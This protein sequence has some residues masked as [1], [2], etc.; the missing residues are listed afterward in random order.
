MKKI[1]ALML[2]LIMV[3]ALVL[4]ACGGGKKDSDSGEPAQGSSVTP[5]PQTSGIDYMALVNKLN[6]LPDGWEE[7]LETVHFTNTVGDDV[8]VEKKAYDAYLELKAELEKEGI[9]VDLD[10]A[11]RS[12]ADQERIMND[13]IEKYG[14]DYAFKT[15]AKPGYSEHH[16]GLALDL[17]LIIDGKDIVENED[18]VQYP[19]IWAKIHSKLANH[20]FIL[21]Y[22]EGRE[23][24]TG[25]G[26]EPWHIRYID[27]VAVAKEI[28]E[29]DI[30]LEEY[31]GAVKS[32]DV[33]IE[34][35]DSDY[36]T[37]EQLKDAVVQIKCKFASYPGCELHSIRYAGDETN[38]ETN[39][40]RMNAIAGEDKYVECAEFLMDFHTPAEGTDTLKPDEE[41]KDYQWWLA[42]EADGGLELVTWGY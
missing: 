21:R 3:M 28:M 33:T 20:G 30:T 32:A 31:L 40:A 24:L 36:Y 1:T 27:D 37:E 5:A 10:S 42:R 18:M 39:I 26:Y 38:L 35:G 19:E 7:A 23:H 12:V 13:F 34:L 41:Y 22:L 9:Y 2:T 25:Y 16:T 8:E 6:P 4:T 17:Y 15:V 14:Q 29:K 11:R